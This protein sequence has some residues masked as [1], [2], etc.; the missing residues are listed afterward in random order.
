MRFTL[1]LSDTKHRTG[2]DG[3]DGALPVG[4]R[5]PTER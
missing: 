4:A 3:P 2:H 1:S 5:W